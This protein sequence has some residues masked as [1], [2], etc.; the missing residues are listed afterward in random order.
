MASEENDKIA[1][2]SPDALREESSAITSYR[3]VEIAV[4][5]LMRKHDFD[6]NTLRQTLTGASIVSW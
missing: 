6:L 3:Y 1:V 2:Q 5:D 4:L